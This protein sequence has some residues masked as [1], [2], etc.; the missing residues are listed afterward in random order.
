[1][2]PSQE[3]AIRK[4][5]S[6]LNYSNFSALGL[7]GQLE[8]EDFSSEDASF[9]VAFIE[10]AGGVDWLEQAAGKAQSYLDFSSFSCQGLIDQ[11]EY[12]KFTPQQATHGATST[13]I[14]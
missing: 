1:M 8:Y 9:A 14:C 4:A 5:E 12:E 7:I 13:G 11:L 6:Y 2:T 3:Q 10:Q